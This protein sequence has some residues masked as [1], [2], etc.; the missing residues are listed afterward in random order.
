MFKEEILFVESQGGY[1]DGVID[2][3]AR[4]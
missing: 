2:L 3:R 1:I 4:E